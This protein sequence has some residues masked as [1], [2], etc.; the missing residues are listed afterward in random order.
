MEPAEPD[1]HARL[2]SIDASERR[3]TNTVSVV[4][5]NKADPGIA[6]TLEALLLINSPQL[7]E[8][9]VVDASQHALDDVRRSFPTVTWI[10]YENLTRKARTI[11]EQRN[12]GVANSSGDVVVFLDSNCIPG[13]C[14]LEQLVTPIFEAGERI[15]VGR[16]TSPTGATVHDASSPQGRLAPTYLEE[17]ANMNVAYHRD[18]LDQLHGFDEQLGFAEDVDFAWRARDAGLRIRFEPSAA[19]VHDWGEFQ[20]DLSRAFRYGVARVRLYRKHTSR[21]GNLARSDRYITAY[22]LYVIAL[23]IALFFP[24]YLLLLLYPVVKNRGHRPLLTVTYHLIY[25]TGV[26]SELCHLPTFRRK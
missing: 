18:V 1:R 25:A 17:C 10:D 12:L 13:P 21:I 19:I 14:W 20:E 26:I 24:A 9:V 16:I 2:Q 3:S 23:P 8:I 5:V 6:R 11:A 15:V 22:T 7:L 4:L